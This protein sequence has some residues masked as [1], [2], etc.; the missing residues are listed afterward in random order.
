MDYLRMNLHASI[1]SWLWFLF[2]SASKLHIGYFELTLHVSIAFKV[3]PS[4]KVLP[5][6]PMSYFKMN[7]NM[8]I[9]FRVRVSYNFVISTH[10]LISTNKKF[11]LYFLNN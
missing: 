4:F 10:I 11:G 8:A 9:A 2:K 7:L 3:G 1:A 6:S 5:K